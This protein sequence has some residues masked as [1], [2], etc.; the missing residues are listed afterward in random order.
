MSLFLAYNSRQT[1]AVTILDAVALLELLLNKCH[2]VQDPAQMEKKANKI[3]KNWVCDFFHF[4]FSVLF[5]PKLSLL[6]A[7][8]ATT[9][10]LHMISTEPWLASS[11]WF[12]SSFCFQ[13]RT[14]CDNWH[15]FLQARRPFCHPT[16][17][18]KLTVLTLSVKRT[19]AGNTE[20]VA[21]E[22]NS[23]GAV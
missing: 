18:S 9:L 14:F 8:S 22:A 11:P 6:P 16:A 5:F 20:S 7:S 23:F 4:S 19:L 12:S 15:W 3:N 17:S 10:F 13:K 21:C 1:I 2:F